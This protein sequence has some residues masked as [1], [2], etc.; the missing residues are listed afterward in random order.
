[1]FAGERSK[2]LSSSTEGLQVQ[3]RQGSG[4]T[5]RLPT[6]GWGGDGHHGA[7]KSPTMSARTR[8]YLREDV[9]LLHARIVAAAFCTK[10]VDIESP[11]HGS[12]ENVP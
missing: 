6:A 7:S 9:S 2:S 12:L 5:L 3:G 10:G 1:M 8:A 4:D 11:L